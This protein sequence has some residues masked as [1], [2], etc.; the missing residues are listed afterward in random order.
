MEYNIAATTAN[1]TSQD[2]GNPQA[3]S[4]LYCYSWDP[5]AV[6]IQTASGGY[7]RRALGTEQE[8]FE[9]TDTISNGM[10]ILGYAYWA[11]YDFGAVAGHSNI[12]YLTV[13]GIDPLRTTSVTGNPLPLTPT[14]LDSVTLRNIQ[15]GSYRIWS[16]FRIVTVDPNATTVASSLAQSTQ[17][18]ASIGGSSPNPITASNLTVL[19][20]HFIPLAGAG[21]PITAS[22]GT[23]GDIDSIGGSFCSATEAG[24]DVGG[25][26]LT[27]LE[28]EN[29]CQQQFFAG[30]I[31]TGQTGLRR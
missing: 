31:A 28:N 5:A 8:L 22:N 1:Q 7:R 16:I 25:Q 21:E 26:V 4:Q 30:Q 19:G 18:Q 14:Q 24:G 9:L 11:P 10:N 20:S 6:N 15:N 23:F 12:H 29:Y 27:L 2:Y 17:R 3:G 13:D